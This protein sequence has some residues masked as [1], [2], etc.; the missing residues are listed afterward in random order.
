MF[1][2]VIEDRTLI[3]T[4]IKALAVENEPEVKR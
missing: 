4:F 2:H 3:Q 1:G